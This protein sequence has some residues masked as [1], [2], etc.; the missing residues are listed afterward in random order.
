[1]LAAQTAV[2]LPAARAARLRARVMAHCDDSPYAIVPHRAEDFRPFIPGVK[3]RPL[4]VDWEGKTQ[5]SLWRLEPGASIPPH[6]HTA[7]EE[8]LIMEGSLI[9]GGKE[10]GPG[11]FLLARPGAHHEEFRSPKGA[12][13]MIRSELS[14]PLAALFAAAAR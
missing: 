7:E 11:D 13:L 14:Q 3:I 9:W 10:Y 5:T 2:E 4:R 6:R 12:L 8:C 1:M